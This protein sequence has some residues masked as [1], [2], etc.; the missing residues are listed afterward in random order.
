MIINR[1]LAFLRNMMS[2]EQDKVRVYVQGNRVS[3]N[4]ELY[5]VD[6][7]REVKDHIVLEPSEY[8]IVMKIITDEHAKDALLNST[9]DNSTIRYASYLRLHNGK[10]IKRLFKLKSKRLTTE[11]HLDLSLI[12]D[13]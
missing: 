13:D 9:A 5:F 12:F 3:K 11:R 8:N 2:D 4:K 10:P 1:L 6:R 7:H